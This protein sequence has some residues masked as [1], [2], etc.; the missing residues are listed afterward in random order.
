MAK[1]TESPGTFTLEQ[2]QE[3][4]RIIVSEIRKPPVDPI[5]EVQKA[6]EKATKETADHDRWQKAITRVL[7]CSHSRQ[8]GTCVIG[9]ARQSDNI[10]RGVCPNCNIGMPIG[11]ELKQLAEIVDYAFPGT[12]DEYRDGLRARLRNLYETQR[13]RPRGLMENV[14]YVA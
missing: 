13:Q 3:A 6:R 12:T 2:F 1:E 8:D 10:E 9:W 11:P 7:A 4:M 5:K 14:R